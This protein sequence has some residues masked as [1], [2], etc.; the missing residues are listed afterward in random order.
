MWKTSGEKS[1]SLSKLWSGPTMVEVKKL[2]EIN[3]TV[4]LRL[5]SVHLGVLSILLLLQ[6]FDIIK[7]DPLYFKGLV[8]WVAVNLL[9]FPAARRRF[10]TPKI[11]NPKCHYCGSE[12]TTVELYCEKCKSSSKAPKKESG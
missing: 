6:V 8:V 2:L 1:K 12:M 3:P 4:E 7:M 10:V 9:A 11:V 5:S